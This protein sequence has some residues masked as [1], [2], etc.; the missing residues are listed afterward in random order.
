MPW[1]TVVARGVACDHIQHFAIGLRR[2]DRHG[3]MAVSIGS[4]GAN[5]AAAGVFDGDGAVW[6]G[7]SAN[8]GPVT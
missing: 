7:V 3:E 8:A 2:G 5:N 6:L 4:A 1:L